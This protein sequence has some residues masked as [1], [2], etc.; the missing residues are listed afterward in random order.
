MRPISPRRSALVAALDVGSSKIACLIARLRPHAPQQVVPRRSHSVEVVG[1]GHAA[2]RDTKAGAVV[3]LAEAEEAI[4]Q[5]VDGA[6]VMA[7]VEIESVVLSISSGRLAG[8]MIAADDDVVGS[9]VSE[10]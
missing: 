10:R 3:N 8:E 7:S 6:E 2:A 4:R 1:F 5:A 9:A